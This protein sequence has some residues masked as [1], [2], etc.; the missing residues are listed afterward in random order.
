MAWPL[1]RTTLLRKANV[2]SI[3]RTKRKV[4]GNESK[5]EDEAVALAIVA[6][7]YKKQNC[8]KDAT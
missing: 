8:E 2:V 4:K 5:G 3:Q 7:Y 1:V 6:K